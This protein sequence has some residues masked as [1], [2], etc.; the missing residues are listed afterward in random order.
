MLPKMQPRG[1]FFNQQPNLLTKSLKE[2]ENL[3][4]SWQQ[5]EGLDN[6]PLEERTPEGFLAL[7]SRVTLKSWGM[8]LAAGGLYS[9]TQQ[10]FNHQID[11]I[12]KDAK[13]EF[14]CM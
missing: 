10:W 2:P 12:R 1:K 3:E 8:S 9:C 7:L 5:C 13:L 4:Q 11:D 14:R 6:K